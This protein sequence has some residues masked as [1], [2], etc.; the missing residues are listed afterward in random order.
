MQALVFAAII[1]VAGAQVQPIDQKKMQP[2]VE[3]TT[4]AP[5]LALAQ[6]NKP[7]QG[8]Q[9]W[10]IFPWGN[11]KNIDASVIGAWNDDMMAYYYL[12][13]VYATIAKE[14]AV[15]GGW[16]PKALQSSTASFEK[17]GMNLMQKPFAQ[18]KKRVEKSLERNDEDE[19]AQTEEAAP[20]DEESSEEGSFMEVA[21]A[22]K[23]GKGPLGLP[24]VDYLTIWCKWLDLAANW[25]I[26]ANTYMGLAADYKALRQPKYT[27]FLSLWTNLVKLHWQYCLIYT[28]YLTIINEFN[29]V[30]FL[31]HMSAYT[32]RTFDAFVMMWMTSS[33]VNLYISV[34]TPMKTAKAALGF[35]LAV[36]GLE[37][38]RILK[39]IALIS[40]LIEFKVP[41]ASVFKGLIPF[42]LAD[43]SIRI[44]WNSATTRAAA[45]L[46]K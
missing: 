42:F 22:K 14:V 34:T 41:C 28:D 19:E 10:W 23:K 1:A 11:F 43:F 18:F 5:V 39:Q 38:T 24:K 26:T 2:L 21:V 8:A 37:L 31:P 44:L 20:A 3:A 25:H 13:I 36:N 4:K 45:F 46:A 27:T 32:L 15:A 35:S 7:A 9:P 30:P 29:T 12:W 6:A 33:Y 16:M 40:Y 17:T